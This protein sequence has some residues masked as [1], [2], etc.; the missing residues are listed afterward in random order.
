[1]HTP[2]QNLAAVP[3]TA[4]ARVKQTSM[5][6]GENKLDGLTNLRLELHFEQPATSYWFVLVLCIS[7]IR[8]NQ[9]VR[10]SLALKLLDSVLFPYKQLIGIFQSF[11]M[12][13]IKMWLLSQLGTSIRFTLVFPLWQRRSCPAPLNGG[14]GGQTRPGPPLLAVTLVK[15]E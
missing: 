1:M 14:V 4:C 11:Y 8:A 12:G 7:P 9:W 10:W 3:A 5:I 2:V 15:M 13:L 6:K